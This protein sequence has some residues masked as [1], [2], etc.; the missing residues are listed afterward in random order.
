MGISQT[1]KAPQPLAGQL[2]GVKLRWLGHSAFEVTSP[3]GT[4]LLLDP[5]ITGNPVTPAEL[6]DLSRYEASD[7]PAAILVSHSHGDHSG[8]AK[9]IALASGA[10]VVGM[11]EF[12]SSLG[13]P[14]EQGRAA[15]WAARSRSAT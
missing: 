1:M 10:P 11:V 14:G 8:D 12:I 6:K 5:F 4:R 13:L 15:T 7:K 2:M 3:N 9:E